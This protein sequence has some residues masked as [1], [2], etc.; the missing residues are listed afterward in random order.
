M[1]TL[2]KRIMH[3]QNNPVEE[4]PFRSRF[5][6]SFKVISVAV[7]ATFLLRDAAWAIDY[8]SVTNR[9]KK[10]QIETATGFL[11]SHIKQQQ[12]KHEE[13]VQGKNDKLVISKSVDQQFI[14]KVRDIKPEL[15]I[16]EQPDG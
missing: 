1:K 6:Y 13:F 2:L 12:Q 5:S 10:K 9:L 11:P 7:L 15:Q 8:G 16:Q 14:D 4:K 3:M